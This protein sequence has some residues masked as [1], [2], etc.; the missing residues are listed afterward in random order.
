MSKKYCFSM[1]RFGED[2]QRGRL[3]AASENT[4]DNSPLLI[5]HKTGVYFSKAMAIYRYQFSKKNAHS[6]IKGT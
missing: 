4:A 2:Q 5:G 3:A 6:G 1:G